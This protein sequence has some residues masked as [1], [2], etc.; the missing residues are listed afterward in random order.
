MRVLL[1][2]F[3]PD[4]EVGLQIVDHRI[5]SFA[6]SDAVDLVECGL[7]EA[8]DDAVV[9]REIGGAS[10]SSSSDSDASTHTAPLSGF[11]R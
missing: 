6:E 4:V 10:R 9:R 5:E 8:L 2:E 11:S 3:A 7:S 1:F